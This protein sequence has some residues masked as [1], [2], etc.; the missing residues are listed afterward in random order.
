MPTLSEEAAKAF[1]A[2]IKNM[3]PLSLD[4]SR[5]EEEN[6]LK[7][8]NQYLD[9]EIR[10]ISNFPPLSV[11]YILSKLSKLEQITFIKNNFEYLQTNDEDVFLYDIMEP[12]ELAYYLSYEALETIYELDKNLFKKIMQ[13]TPEY[14]F[15][16]FTHENYISYFTTFR[17]DI[18][19]ME[20]WQLFRILSEHN[21]CMYNNMDID[22]INAIFESQHEYNKEFITYFI[23][24]YQEKVDTF[25]PRE[26]LRFISYIE[27][28]EEYKKMVFKNRNKIEMALQNM[29]ESDFFGYL[30][31][32]VNEKQQE[33][34]FSNFLET[35]VEKQDIQ[36]IIFAVSSNVI[37]ELWNKNK[38]IF[39]KMTLED[40][41]KLCAKK[42]KFN[43][44]YQMILD[45]YSIYNISK[46]F[47]IDFYRDQWESPS[48][49]PLQYIETKYRN[50]MM[51]NDIIS[52]NQI[53]SI[54]SEEYFSNLKYLQKNLKEKVLSKDSKEYQENLMFFI[55][56]LQSNHI[57][58]DLSILA[59]K[60][61]NYFFN[62]IIKGYPIASILEITSIE[63][64]AEIN[65]LGE[66]IFNSSD[67][68]VEQIEKF[69][70]REYRQL[71][72]IYKVKN[73]AKFSIFS[74]NTLLL[75]LFLLVGFQ[76]TKRIL[77][78]DSSIT[79]IEHLVGNVDVKHVMLDER[80]HSILNSKILNLLFSN[81]SQLEEMLTN[82]ENDIYKYFP[83]IFNEWEAIKAN[84]RD[85][86]LKSVIDF[87]KNDELVLPPNYYRLNGLFRLIGCK[88]NIVEET[89]RLHD[90]MLTR[91]TSTIPKIK[92][93]LGEYTY[94]VLD[95]QDMNG[96]TVGN[97]TDCCFTVLG[98]GYSSL[99][100]AVTSKNGRILV[101]K[102]N[103][104]LLAHSWIWR[105]GNVLCLDNIEVSK[106][107]H[108]VDFLDI[109]LD[110]A[111][112]IIKKS[113]EQEGIDTCIKNVTIGYTN[114]DKNIIGLQDYPC[115]ISKT[116]D[117]K[118]KEFGKK[119]GNN[120][121]MV[122][123]LPKPI[124][125]V[126]YLDAKNAQYLI[127]GKGI[128]EFYQ[129]NDI[130]KDSRNEVL[131]YE[132]KKEYSNEYIEKI[133]Q[134]INA[135][136]YTRCILNNDIDSFEYMNIEHDESVICNVDWFIRKNGNDLDSF[137]YSND[138]RA[139]EEME[140][141]SMESSKCKRMSL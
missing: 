121:E 114:F 16:G 39:D 72:S 124:E 65:R 19:N 139:Y 81:L 58:D 112:S 71:L 69:N 134:I 45:S 98:N 117:L 42:R 38:K 54:F 23:K 115:F 94:E 105:N 14:I 57:V 26:L 75:K 82:K 4:I 67:F 3:K 79:T 60:E 30:H 43:E 11:Y 35:I 29:N 83:R 100:H 2:S 48:I 63:Q 78:I 127:K 84:D 88:N 133:N 107:I 20:S 7:K 136:R 50:G 8:C 141:F 89:L 24:N 59:V 95:L 129:S 104:R 119:L 56:Y 31:E 113:F 109:Y 111:E 135:L 92:K 52:T 116:C 68:T 1:L 85:K 96:L 131:I 47:H 33:I 22:K 74:D 44:N 138:D 61:I 6:A 34:L 77:E 101:V 10:D 128:F 13:G 17:S 140:A 53:T 99:R 49:K 132:E 87:L 21:R 73:K 106:S 46:F 28:I 122:S 91:T 51:V 125:Q 118:E 18:M 102:K 86:S 40:W 123:E 5:V 41:I 32:E 103:D 70:V 80:K 66:E 27:N 108:E 36:T 97:A 93:G 9:G 130:Y 120:R 76:N 90:E 62:K 37:F 15:H 55:A 64:I 12:K 110:F 137:I 126:K 25:T